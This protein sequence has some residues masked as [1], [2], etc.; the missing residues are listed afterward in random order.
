[1]TA[2]I[3]KQRKLKSIGYELFTKIGRSTHSQM[4]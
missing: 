3:V 2:N 1:M 4:N